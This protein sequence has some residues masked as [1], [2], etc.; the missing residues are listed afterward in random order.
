MNSSE[1]SRLGWPAPQ[2]AHPLRHAVSLPG[3]KSLTNREL[4]LAALATGPSRVIR[5]LHSRDTA[6]MVEALRS[7][8]VTITAVEGEGTFGPDFLVEPLPSSPAPV[9]ALID[10]GLAGTVMR[11]IP[12]VAALVAGAT[13]LDGDASARRRPMGTTLDALTQLGVTIEDG[14]SR[15]LPFTMTSPVQLT[16]NSVTID[17]SQSS[18]FVSGLLLAAARMPGGLSITHTGDTLPSLPHIEMTIACLEARG[19]GV[20]TPRTGVWVVEPGPIAPLNVSIEPDLSNSAPF[21]AAA[22]IT[23][24]SVTVD[25]WPAETTQVGAHIPALLERF[26]ATI[27][28]NHSSVTVD[29]GAGWVNGSAL[30]GVDMDLSHAGELAPNLIALSTLAESPSRFRGIGHLRGHETD[31]LSALVENIRALGGIALE[32][33]DGIEVTPAPLDGG[34]WRSFEDHRMATSG[35]LLGLGVRGVVVDD[36]ACTSKTLPEFTDLWRALVESPRA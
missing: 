27:I 34:G 17:A 15:T 30:Q 5:P 3:S 31:R 36:I 10:C 20:S 18:Q 26:G 12:P 25:G 4:V 16:G 22:L 24:G 21:L 8:G 19:V 33:P 2:R 1:N 32:H 14:G 35:A 29:G 9:R 7:L 13:H 28:R 6:L 23:G 11:F